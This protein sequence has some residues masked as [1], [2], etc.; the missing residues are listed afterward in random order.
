MEEVASRAEYEFPVVG[1]ERKDLTVAIHFRSSPRHADLGP[2]VGHRGRRRSGLAVH[3]ARMSYELRPPLPHDKGLV[4]ARSAAGLSH[5]LF[6]GDDRGDLEAFDAL[7]RL[8]GEAT[9]AR[10]AVREQGSPRS[11]WNRPTPS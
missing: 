11:C 1:V 7:D 9:T 6:V 10:V 5:V 2:G 8:A 4:V 3:P